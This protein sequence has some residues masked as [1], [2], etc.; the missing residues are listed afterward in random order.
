MRAIS[1]QFA[2]YRSFRTPAMSISSL[3]PWAKRLVSTFQRLYSP[4]SFEGPGRLDAELASLAD[5]G[6]PLRRDGPAL[7]SAS[8]PT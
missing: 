7:V 3:V 4:S 6:S 2:G 8:D 5:P 1:Q